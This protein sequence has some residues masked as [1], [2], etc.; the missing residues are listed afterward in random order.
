[1][2]LGVR[3]HLYYQILPEPH[4]IVLWTTLGQV[5]GQQ[6]CHRPHCRVFRASWM[7]IMALRD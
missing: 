7:Q 3:F 4:Q 5:L 2:R 6:L 1:M